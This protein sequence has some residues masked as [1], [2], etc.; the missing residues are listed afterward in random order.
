MIE[1]ILR[2]IFVLGSM[3]LVA[4][5]G[6]SSSDTGTSSGST[7]DPV[8]FAMLNTAGSNAKVCAA[9]IQCISSQCSDT[10]KEC[11]G[12]DYA[13]GV[14]A[15][16]CGSYFDCVKGCKCEKTC[17]DTCDPGTTDCASCLSI[18]LAMGCTL[19]CITEIASCGKQ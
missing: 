4:A 11:A 17:V 3:S 7:C 9:T 19:K 12:P 18:D 8:A 15:G 16:T 13:S 10:A 6:S 14:Y 2:G 1:N 5:C